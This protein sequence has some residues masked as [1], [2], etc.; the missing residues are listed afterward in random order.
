[1]DPN[2]ASTLLD[3]WGSDT[4]TPSLQPILD[5]EKPTGTGAQPEPQETNEQ[6]IPVLPD[7]PTVERFRKAYQERNQKEDVPLDI[8]TGLSAGLRARMSFRSTPEDQFKFLQK[9]YGDDNVRL[10][11]DNVP[12]VR[13]TDPKTKKSTDFRSNP[14][15]A[16]P[17]DIVELAGQ[18]PDIA[19]SLLADR[20]IPGGS[21]YGGKLSKEGGIGRKLLSL[22]VMAGGQETGGATKDVATRFLDKSPVNLDEIAKRRALNFGED[23]AVGGALGSTAKAATK[24]GSPFNKLTQETLDHRAAMEH[25]GGVGFNYPSTAAEMTGSPL[26]GRVEAYNRPLPGSSSVFNRISEEQKKTV[27]DIQK[28]MM[29]F[30]PNAPSLEESGAQAMGALSSKATPTAEAAETAESALK[31]TGTSEAAR[32][33][34][35]KIVDQPSIN[36]SE[37]GG[38]LRASAIAK[39]DAFRDESNALYQKVYQHPDANQFNIDSSSLADKARKLLDKLP[40]AET[41]VSEPSQMVDRYGHPIL[42]DIEGKEIQRNFVSPSVLTK[43]ND[44]SALKDG[45]F[46]LGDLLQMRTEVSNEIQRGKAIGNVKDHWMQEIHKALDESIN[47]GLGK[48]KSPELKNLWTQANKHYADNVGKFNTSGISDL[49]RDPEEP[50]FVGNKALVTRAMSGDNAEDVF[51]SYKQFFGRNSTEVNG[52]KQAVKDRIFNDAFDHSTQTVS[53]DKLLQGLGD[54][55]NKNP[56]MAKEVF[57]NS[58][59]GIMQVGK[60]LS[61]GSS[62]EKAMSKV[63]DLKNIINSKFSPSEISDL[64]KRGDLTFSKLSEL[65]DAKE[66]MG[67]MYRNR[68]VSQVTKGDLSGAKMNPSS[69]VEFMSTKADP[70]DIHHAIALLS[71][72]PDVMQQIKS[73][74]IQQIFDQA[75]VRGGESAGVRLAD[76]PGEI[77]SSGMLKALGDSTQKER[78]RSILGADTYR[79]MEELAKL[80]GP[81]E[82]QQRAFS[83]AGGLAAGSRIHQLIKFPLKYASNFVT[84]AIEAN[85]YANRGIR[86]YLANQVVTPEKSSALI[87]GAIT[88][89]PIIKAMTYQFGKEATR[90]YYSQIKQSFLDAQ[91]EGR[92]PDE[93]EDQKREKYR[94]V[95][96]SWGNSIR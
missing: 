17:K 32:Q 34:G 14:I 10:S 96:E 57:G 94:K 91:N 3:K 62:M 66:K 47:D 84:S 51:G 90:K 35:R 21:L 78:Y 70:E 68:I 45:K 33:M 65:A 81:K 46:R 87:Y 23:L 59:T 25:F 74:T 27:Q 49:F 48:L 67:Q 4:N 95:V 53:G 6:G 88:S 60:G 80:L 77:T 50:G 9:E 36:P 16:H 26:L 75:T 37:L 22:I 58:A 15:G 93:T 28:Y 76:S 31:K 42:R 8:D 63:V 2:E 29:D 24:I 39:R 18:I 64:T 30:S 86:D 61:A 12:I 20:F 7:Q 44:L 69:F 83:A 19:A 5:V 79:D 40:A 85:I 11:E 1:M 13:I 71:D 54:F 72:R 92:T 89:E 73:R 56:S 82:T 41:R 52:L 38:N 55:F 43:L